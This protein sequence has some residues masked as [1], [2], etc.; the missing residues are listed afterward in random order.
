MSESPADIAKFNA[1]KRAADYVKDGM[2]V[3]LGTGSTAA[4]LVRILG[5]RVLDGLKFQGVPTSLATSPID[6]YSE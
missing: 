4:H 6:R 2:I 3:G 1:A 5:A